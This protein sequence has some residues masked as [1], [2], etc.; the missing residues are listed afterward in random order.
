[1]VVIGW[2]GRSA[3]V[4]V[5][6][7]THFGEVLPYLTPSG[8]TCPFRPDAE[9]GR[10]VELRTTG[11]TRGRP[12]PDMPDMPI[13]PYTP[14]NLAAAAADRIQV[15][16]GHGQGLAVTGPQPP[17]LLQVFGRE[18]WKRKR[19]LT[20]WTLV[21]AAMAV[22]VVM[23]I[24]KP[25]YRAE[26]RLSYRPNYGGGGPRPIYTP[27][28]IQSTVQI[29]KASDVFEP[30]RAKHTP[31]LS[32]D[33]FARNAHIEMSKQSEF[34]DVSYDDPNPVVAAAIANDLMA[35][36]MKYFT[37]VRVKSTTEAVTQVATDLKRAKSQLDQAK[38]DYAEAFRAK[39]FENPEV[40]L[41]NLKTALAGADSKLL[42]A[43]SRKAQIPLEKQYLE[44]A[45]D[46]PKSENDQGLDERTMS[47]M[48]ALQG[49]LQRQMLDD[50]SLEEAR[51][52]LKAA[53]QKE[54]EYKPLY[55]KQIMP[56]SEY[57]DI[58]TKVRTY[59]AA[60]ERGEKAKAKRAEF[61]KKYDELLVQMKS[62][63]PIRTKVLDELERL[64]TEE[65]T[66]PGKIMV[67]T[68]EQTEKK[69]ALAKLTQT[70][71]E[72][73]TKDEEIHFLRT[74]A[75]DLDSQLSSASGRSLD[76]HAND[77]RVHANAVTPVVAYST[78]APKLGLAL[79]GAS[80]LLFIGYISLFG[81]PKGTITGPTS[82][83]GL[84]HNPAP[85]GGLLPRALVALVPY[86]QKPKADQA[87]LNGTASEGMSPPSA[88]PASTEAAAP[89]Q[90][91][92]TVDAVVP[93]APPLADAVTD[94]EAVAVAEPEPVRA[95]AQMIVDE[96][97]EHGGIVLF[98][99][100]DDK[101][102]LAPAIGDLGQYFSD[103][104]DRVLVF[105]TRKSADTPT[106]VGGNGV[107][108]TVAGYLNGLADG[109]TGC[110]VPTA[111]RG[112]E[113]SRVNLSNPVAGVMEAHRFRQLIEQMRERYSVV[114]LVGPPLNL[115]ED[116][117][118]LASMAEGM[119]LVTETAANP[120]EVHAYLDTLCQQ[121]P[122]RLYGTLAVPKT[123]A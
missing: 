91:T 6:C 8:I 89:M 23:T 31:S 13:Q 122:A 93:A 67:L 19:L 18:V 33:D 38:M 64:R 9:F 21:T 75:Q 12:D 25:V 54:I 56:R 116:H 61:Q 100:T 55:V 66:L 85:G 35:E 110:F 79:V 17:T 44:T 58:L 92:S 10:I 96:G 112:V 29:L 78:N 108:D 3:M 41:D 27:P 95:L 81:L 7:H 22:V 14:Q 51:I 1:M 101:L 70:H 80:A 69:S 34:I 59:E 45:R 107:A 102:P 74:R 82:A 15:P 105:E 52:N 5:L 28:N 90:S 99:P 40:E 57:E 114:F 48:S 43:L 121:V 30:I 106:W 46:A 47:A 98:S 72:M 37:D 32:P 50:Q 20:V 118:L 119:V 88:A 104:G 53:R 111:L 113:Y 76:P 115:E 117:P 4:V 83:G 68:R 109:T 97:V 11:P 65:A 60:V 36:G 120:V 123:A 39:G 2:K 71:R 77:L 103:R 84:A 26:G 42:E 73:G 62:G 49:D 63:K 16:A 24:A 87:A 94:T 86:V